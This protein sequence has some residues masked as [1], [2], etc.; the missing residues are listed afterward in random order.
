MIGENMLCSN[1][2]VETQSA[3]TATD[4]KGFSVDDRAYPDLTTL[5]K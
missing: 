4:I 1:L 2:Y 5:Y 3:V